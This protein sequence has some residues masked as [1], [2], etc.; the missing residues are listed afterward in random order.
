MHVFE[1]ESLARRSSVNIQNIIFHCNPSIHQSQLGRCVLEVLTYF[2]GNER[3]GNAHHA[4]ESGRYAQF[5]PIHHPKDWSLRGWGSA[6]NTS[7]AP[8]PEIAIDDPWSP[9]ISTQGHKTGRVSSTALTWDWT[10]T[11]D[12][13]W[14]NAGKAHRDI[15]WKG[16]VER[17]MTY[18]NVSL[19]V[20]FQWETARDHY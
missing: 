16:R 20:I 8:A 14:L 6:P 17:N 4:F 2:L 12:W 15:E 10:R 18:S 3:L 9:R 19:C 11:Q 5:H 1:L 7:W 13:R